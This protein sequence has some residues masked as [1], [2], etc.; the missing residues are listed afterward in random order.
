MRAPCANDRHF[1][2]IDARCGQSRDATFLEET[3]IDYLVPHRAIESA[4]GGA[5]NVLGASEVGLESFIPDPQSLEPAVECL[6]GFQMN[7]FRSI[8]KGSNSVKA[9][10]IEFIVS[11]SL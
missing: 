3:P 10:T 5:A 9:N 2:S 1:F 6:E 8:P 7:T 4:E 11:C